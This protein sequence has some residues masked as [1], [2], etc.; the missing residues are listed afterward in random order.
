[1]RTQEQIDKK[2]NE[3][4]KE[5][6]QF[7]YGAVEARYRNSDAKPNEPK[8]SKAYEAEKLRIKSA[9]MNKAFG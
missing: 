4:T 2:L 5:D 1:M 8:N 9:L 3:L 7:I 6:W